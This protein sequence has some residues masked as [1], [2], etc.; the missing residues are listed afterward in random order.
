MTETLDGKILGL[1]QVKY[2]QSINDRYLAGKMNYDISKS[3]ENM[4]LS[5]RKAMRDAKIIDQLDRNKS[6]DQRTLSR[7]ER[8]YDLPKFD[9]TDETS[10]QVRIQSLGST[11]GTVADN[12]EFIQTEKELKIRKE[13]IEK[14]ADVPSKKLVKA[15]PEDILSFSNLLNSKILGVDENAEPTEEDSK[16]NA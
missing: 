13:F 9:A 3:Q 8:E 1:G 12:V 10:W 14:V 4:F 11:L 6:E 16:S 2:D 5:M 7:I 15:K